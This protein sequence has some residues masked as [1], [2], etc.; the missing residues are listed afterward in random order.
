VAEQRELQL[1]VRTIA[2]VQGAN[3][4][5]DALQQLR[6]TAQQTQQVLP[7]GGGAAN[8]PFGTQL[9]QALQNQP[10]SIRSQANAFETQRKKL[11]DLGVSGAELERALDDFEPPSPRLTGQ[12]LGP[13][14]L[15]ARQA[16]LAPAQ[17]ADDQQRAARAIADSTTAVRANAAAARD[18][19]AAHKE[20]SGGLTQGEAN[21]LRFATAITG[22]NQGFSLFSTAGNLVNQAI[23]ATIKNTVDAQQSAKDLTAAY[24]SAATQFQAFAQQTARAPEAFS[25]ADIQRASV[26]IKP[27]AQQFQLSAEQS[28]ELVKAATRLADIHDIPLTQATA[29]LEGALRGDSSAA[30]QLGLSLSDTQVAARAAGGA[31]ATSFAGLPDYQKAQLRM[32]V[33][34]EEVNEQQKNT[35][36][37][38]DT[39]SRAQ[40]SAATA[41][42]DLA[43]ATAGGPLVA[44]A[45][46]L[47]G[48]VAKFVEGLRDLGKQAEQTQGQTQG[49]HF[50]DDAGA[51]AARAAIQT[52]KL[53]EETSGIESDAQRAASA[54][55]AYAAQQRSAAQATNDLAGELSKLQA[56]QGQISSRAG[57]IAGGRSILGIG[58]QDL[59]VLAQAQAELDVIGQRATV[60]ASDPNT[61]LRK[62]LED[63]ANQPF[64]GDE[65]ANIR[66]ARQEIE[67]LDRVAEARRQVLAVQQAQAEL[68]RQAVILGA[69]EAQAQLNALPQ[70]QA[71]QGQNDRITRDRLLAQN[72]FLTPADRIAARRD[73]RTASRQLPGFELQA[74]DASA[75][76]RTIAQQQQ[77]QTLL[78]Q[79]AAGTAAQ[80]QQQLD[81]VHRG[82]ITVNVTGN[83]V[84]T[85]SQ[86]DKESIAQNAAEQAHD[87]VVAALDQATRD[88]DRAAPSSL[89][90]TGP[91]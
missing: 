28:Q 50:L 82:D 55:A 5:R 16:A 13:R 2:D 88:A 68:Q 65:A 64:T 48:L 81:V 8:D 34:L 15:A 61:A 56:V 11:T 43:N 79:V 32:A 18:A 37:S 12:P 36:G 73:L 77:R 51:A 23:Q 38:A 7:V 58:P 75:D 71:L 10:A 25:V 78:G 6:Q 53:K 24:G 19:A 20:F 85:L 76:A 44:G 26:A 27:L 14:Q 74:F 86:A 84:A 1:I 57:A 9:R 89:T 21:A 30:D 17:P 80:A 41:T 72:R 90:G 91:R 31:F 60:Q 87:A 49:F 63:V 46:A 42:S 29:A 70:T 67:Q 54:F 40:R 66:R 47:T 4:T 52:Q 39:L 62:Q 35:A 22:I 59:D 3:Q 45:T 33:L 83:P 69:Q